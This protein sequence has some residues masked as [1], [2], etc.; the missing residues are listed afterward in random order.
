MDFYTKISL[1][2]NFKARIGS[3][4]KDLKII[5]GGYHELYTDRE[6]RLVFKIIFDWLKKRTPDKNSYVR[7]KFPINIIV[8]A[9][10]QTRWK[11]NIGVVSAVLYILALY[12]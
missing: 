11:R 1:I 8:K 5:D 10:S 2:R 7:V 4:D 6:K 9:E 12:W 3:T